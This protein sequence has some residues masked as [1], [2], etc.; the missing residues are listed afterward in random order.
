MNKNTRQ[1]RK[2]IARA[3]GQKKIEVEYVRP[4]GDYHND[5]KPRLKTMRCPTAV[6]DSTGTV[7]ASPRRNM[8]MIVMRNKGEDGRGFSVTRHVPITEGKP[9][10]FKNHGQYKDWASGYRQPASFR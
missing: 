3:S 9:I 10:V 1:L 6:P 5:L 7:S 4:T 8:R 2:V